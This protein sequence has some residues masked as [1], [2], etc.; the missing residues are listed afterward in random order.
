MKSAVN[1]PDPSRSRRSAKHSSFDYVHAV[2]GYAG[3]AGVRDRSLCVQRFSSQRFNFTQIPI[4]PASGPA[5]GSFNGLHRQ[6][7]LLAALCMFFVVLGG[8]LALAQ[9]NS[10]LVRGEITENQI[11]GSRGARY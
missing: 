6:S 11:P 1:S 10:I 3:L 8:T 2:C 7:K 4:F 9:T 5:T